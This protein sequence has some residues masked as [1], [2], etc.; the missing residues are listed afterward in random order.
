MQIKP[1]PSKIEI[2]KE[3]ALKWG[4]YLEMENCDPNLVIEILLNTIISQQA[5]IEYLT[6]IEKEFYEG[7][8]NGTTD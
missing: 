8:R 3:L 6:K 4:E 1:S 2:I 7:K 5:R